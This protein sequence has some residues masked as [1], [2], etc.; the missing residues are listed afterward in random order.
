MEESI[1]EDELFKRKVYQIYQDDPQA[2]GDQVKQIGQ[3]SV[4]LFSLDDMIKMDIDQLHGKI[5]KMIEVKPNG[6]A[7]QSTQNFCFVQIKRSNSKIGKTCQTV[8]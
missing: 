6:M 8:L 4:D 2:T 1:S 5:F 3:V 7:P